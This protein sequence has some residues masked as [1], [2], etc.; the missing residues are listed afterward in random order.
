MNKK[1]YFLFSFIV[2]LAFSSCKKE[3]QIVNQPVVDNYIYGVNGENL[4]QSNVE[5]D[6]SGIQEESGQGYV[7]E[8]DSDEPVPAKKS[9]SDS[10]GYDDEEFKDQT[11]DISPLM[12]SNKGNTME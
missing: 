10:D 11:Q 5:K 1:T 3:T 6:K 7:H 9:D 12:E 4:Y 2:L 8:L